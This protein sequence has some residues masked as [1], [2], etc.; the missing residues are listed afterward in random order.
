MVG[1][2][3]GLPFSQGVFV[4]PAAGGPVLD[5]FTTPETTGV[6]ALT[7]HTPDQDP[8]GGGYFQPPG[9]FSGDGQIDNATNRLQTVVNDNLNYGAALLVD[10]F[11]NKAFVQINFD[12][13][14]PYLAG[15]NERVFVGVADPS[16]GDAVSFGVTAIE[17]GGSQFFNVFAFDTVL[18]TT[19]TI[20]QMN[21]AATVGAHVAKMTWDNVNIVLD[22]DGTTTTFPFSRVLDIGAVSPLTGS[23]SPTRRLFMNSYN[24]VNI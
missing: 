6:K 23:N 1:I 3:I 18:G 10:G 4:P 22:L 9:A 24:V 8:L 14:T 12:L 7:L 5:T 16:N 11:N 2:G 21:V 20:G 15:E 19:T 17:S 13:D